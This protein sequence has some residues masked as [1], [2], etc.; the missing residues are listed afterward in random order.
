MPLIINNYQQVPSN[1]QFFIKTKQKYTIF[2]PLASINRQFVTL[3]V[4]FFYN[5]H[6]F[7]SLGGLFLP[8]TH[9][10]GNLNCFFVKFLPLIGL[11]I[12][13]LVNLFPH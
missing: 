9:L 10:F 7:W 11:R 5:F 13:I 3:N 12:F 8:L 2:F 6:F 4:L 1:C